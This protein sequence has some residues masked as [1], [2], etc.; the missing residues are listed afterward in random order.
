VK[1]YS[2]FGLVLVAI[3]L[4]G[5][6][7]GTSRNSGVRFGGSRGWGTGYDDMRLQRIDTRTHGGPGVLWCVVGYG[8]GMRPLWC[9]LDPRGAAGAR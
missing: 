2:I 1:R 4:V 7:C 8:G 9:T 3:V 6:A 5:S